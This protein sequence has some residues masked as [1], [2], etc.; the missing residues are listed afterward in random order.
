MHYIKVRTKVLNKLKLSIIN[1]NKN[2]DG[3]KIEKLLHCY[4]TSLRLSVTRGRKIDTMP[5]FAYQ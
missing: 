1:K 4:A 5:P 3:H 2:E